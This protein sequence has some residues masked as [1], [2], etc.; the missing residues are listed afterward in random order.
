M[1]P[2]NSNGSSRE[3][4]QPQPQP[5]QS[6]ED[7]SSS[8]NINSSASSATN[9]S[10]SSTHR[11]TVSAFKAALRS[12]LHIDHTQVAFVPGLRT[13]AILMIEWSVF[14]IG[15]PTSTA[16]Q[17]GC[18]YTA[19]SDPNGNLTRR[20]HSM[21]LTLVCLLV[22]GTLLP[23]L[24]W[25]YPVAHFVLALAVAGATGLSP[26]LNSPELFLAMK[27]STALFAIYGAVNRNT[28]GYGGLG[29]ILLWTFFGG[30]MSF[31]AAT[32]PELIG[33]R[34]AVRTDLF[35]T[36]HGLGWNMQKWSA[37]WGTQEHVNTAPIPYTTISICKT[38]DRIYHDVYSPLARQWLLKLM[39]RADGIR[40]AALCLS[41]GYEMAKQA[42]GKQQLR[43][44][45]MDVLFRILGSTCRK[46][47]TVVQFPWT[48]K[49]IPSVSRNLKDSA[50][51]IAK[52]SAV[53]KS[54][55]TNEFESGMNW[56]PALLDLLQQEV[57]G[58]V[59]M[60]VDKKS[61]PPYSKVRTIPERIL[62]A[63]PTQ[64]E[65]LKDDSDWVIRGY[66]LRFGLAFGLATIPELVM[67]RGV[68][69]HWFPMTV[70][71]IMG[72][73]QAATF[74]KVVHRTV[75]TL[76]GIGLG[77]SLYPL[78]DYPQAL[79][80]LMGFMTYASVTF[81]IPSYVLF[82]FSIT[83][84]VFCTTVGTGA[85]LGKIVFYRCMWTLASAALV[86]VA[87]YIYPPKTEYNVTERLA[88]MARATK[89]FAHAVSEEHRLR[90]DIHS[91]HEE[92]Q[93]RIGEGDLSTELDQAQQKVNE[94]RKTAIQARV[95]MLTCIHDAVLTPSEPTCINLHS[96]APA[97]AS[98]LIDAVVVPQFVSLVDNQHS[99]DLLSWVELCF[100]EET[101]TEI[102]RLIQRLQSSACL[103]SKRGDSLPKPNSQTKRST[104]QLQF[105]LPMAIA[106]AHQRLD[107]AGVPG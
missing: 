50:D 63:F 65:G 97:L 53:L 89:E 30:S 101:F 98:D 79:I 41:N 55:V 54:R 12:L 77:A 25:E 86:T 99:D 17:L 26:L 69:G 36:F 32:L 10:S 19:L 35:K 100:C 4:D 2:S 31:L 94:T 107:D 7:D 33:N 90:C 14:G 6:C 91:C 71:L 67:A 60:L 42:K 106:H 80:V 96:V 48:V 34:D 104:S 15:N 27:L 39:E 102:D 18:L 20:F 64:W 3:E 9:T 58:A 16:F 47:G 44:T 72:P 57:E 62:R 38:Q 21:G 81:F 73:T 37:H 45:E 5:Q 59:D 74:P 95:A 40:T 1:T 24:V 46:A 75:G 29:A 105:A 22:F 61:W 66:A 83:G 92:Q 68:S 93:T 28:Q 87:T 84:W 52:A 8:S 43:H 13:A 51:Q 78:F 85:H 11:G 103:P 56:L 23:G 88:D 76:L 70:A 49:Y 82:T